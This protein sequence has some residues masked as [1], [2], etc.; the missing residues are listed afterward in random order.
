LP[1]RET[2]IKRIRYIDGLPERE[3]KRYMVEIEPKIKEREKMK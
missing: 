3:I 1:H 2:E